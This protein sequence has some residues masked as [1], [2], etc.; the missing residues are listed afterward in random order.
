MHP[1]PKA[2]Q[3]HAAV[4]SRGQLHGEDRGLKARNI[5]RESKQQRDILRGYARDD[6]SVPL[7]MDRI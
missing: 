6:T 7:Q 2:R 1:M 3:I 4:S 5:K